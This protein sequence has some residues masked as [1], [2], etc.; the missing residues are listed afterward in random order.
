MDW[1]ET[2]TCLKTNAHQ[3]T[4]NSKQ[5]RVSLNWRLLFHSSIRCTHSTIHLRREN[6]GDYTLFFNQFSVIGPVMLK[7]Q[8]HVPVVNTHVAI[9]VYF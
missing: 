8:R 4:F 6:T 9:R 3:R 7:S 5:E 2:Y 1:L